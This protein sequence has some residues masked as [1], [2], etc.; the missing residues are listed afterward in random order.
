MGI[1]SDDLFAIQFQDESQHTVSSRVLRS[2]V[3][4]VMSD[5]SCLILVAEVL[6]GCLV[7][8][9]SVVLVD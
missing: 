9:Q 3:D 2:E 4:R 6:V 1:G 8:V 5:F 7:D